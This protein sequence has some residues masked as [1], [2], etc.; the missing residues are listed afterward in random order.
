MPYFFKM[1]GSAWSSKTSARLLTLLGVMSQ[2]KPFIGNRCCFHL[3]TTQHQYKTRTDWGCWFPI[4]IHVHP[5][6]PFPSVWLIIRPHC[7]VDPLHAD[8][9]KSTGQSS[10]MSL[11]HGLV[12]TWSILYITLYLYFAELGPLRSLWIT[13]YAFQLA[14]ITGQNLTAHSNICTFILLLPY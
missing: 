14:R 6:Q 9:V 1:H 13:Y 8:V 3:W 11:V 10:G 7:S 2:P 12:Q 5:A 4:G